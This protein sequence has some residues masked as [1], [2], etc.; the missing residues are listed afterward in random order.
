MSLFGERELRRVA[1]E[2]LRHA[3]GDAA[4][5]VVIARTGSLTRFA[6][7]AIHQNLVSR[8]ADVHVRVAVGKRV[9]S[10][11]TNRIDAEGLAKVAREA[12]ALARLA[13][14]NDRF[15]GIPE[16]R[17]LA[18]T[19]SAFRDR[20]AAA[21]AM[22]RAKAAKVIC[23]ASHAKG[24]RAAGFVSTDV[25]EL[26]VANTK[27]VWA[28]APNTVSEAQAAVLGDAGSS[29]GQ[30]VALDFGDLDAEAVATE[31]V[32]KTLRAQ[33]PRDFPVGAHEV[34]LEPYATRD[35][36]GMLSGQLTGLAVEEGRSFMAGRFGEKV[37]GDFTLVDDTFDPLGVPR[38]FDF[39][40]QPTERVTII[41]RGVAK[42]V[43]WDAGTARRARRAP[44]G[45][46]TPE[47]TIP[48][49]P[50]SL[51]FEPGDKSRE[52]LVKGI[53]R[54]V[55]VTRFW[56]VRWVHQ[57][58]TIVTGM[59]RDG[60]FAI[61]NGEIAYPVKNFRFTDSIHGSLGTLKGIGSELR[62]IM[63]TEQ[64]GLRAAWQRVP[65][66]HLGAFTFTGATQY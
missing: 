43:V 42:D 15:P 37:T 12:S 29:F 59:T 2:A 50:M 44:T 51:R 13:P 35:L 27:G 8:E 61:E 39:E 65:A 30:R 23:D 46:A 45:H 54:G 28:Y 3:T 25:Q 33:R 18:A 41:E 62:L 66:V 48:A 9:A 20:T 7:S 64:F 11:S 63:P 52:Q 24:L 21:S 10:L 40:G 34:V 47:R 19:A 1:D 60:T 58:R 26:A 49:L 5:A 22:D 6:N 53:R 55:L 36:I 4:E 56:Y 57:L 38:A 32:T 14:E 31:A 16:A 17:P